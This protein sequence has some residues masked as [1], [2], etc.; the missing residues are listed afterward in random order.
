MSNRT[1]VAVEPGGDETIA[2]KLSKATG[3]YP[4]ARVPKVFDCS[5]DLM[6]PWSQADAVRQH[7]RTI[8][9]KLGTHDAIK[10]ALKEIERIAPPQVR[11]L[12]FYLVAE[13]AERFS[14]EA[15]CDTKGTFFALD[16]RWPIG[17]MA[18][19]AVD[20][21]LPRGDFAGPLRVMALLSALRYPAERQWH[22]LRDAAIDSQKNGLEVQLQVYVG[23]E[24]LLESIRKDIAQGALAWVTAEPVPTR[25]AD[26]S[27]ALAK[28]SPHVLHFYCHGSATAGVPQL[29]LA[30]ITDWDDDKK[31]IGSFIVKV[32][33]LIGF[34]ALASTWLVTL[35][36]CEGARAADDLHSMAHRIVAGGVPAAVGMSEPIDA[37]DAHEFASMFYPTL[38][39]DLRKALD[40]ARHNGGTSEFEW[41]PSLHPAR[42]VLRDTHAEGDA[43]RAWTLPVL[44][45]RPE[46]FELRVPTKPAAA[47]AFRYTDHEKRIEAVAG[48][49]RTQPAETP[50]EV[51]AEILA[52]LNDVPEEFRPRLDGTFKTSASGNGAGQ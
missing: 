19:S 27:A 4:D 21:G 14:W 41:A 38:F 34:P 42:T 48:I 28:F 11:S 26:L 43:N 7:G 23:E 3:A 8:Y 17:R 24:T 37:S 13:V 52:L 36:C 49:L 45:V 51:R 30:T 20:Q 39:A 1:V 32:D 50:P 22:S 9:D 29:Q 2:V 46:P 31:E 5:P 25:V 16:R 18:D 6:P 33:E 47:A 15:L 44:Y 10:E 35:N 12:Y 40:A